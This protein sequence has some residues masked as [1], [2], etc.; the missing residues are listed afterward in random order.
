MNGALHSSGLKPPGQVIS[1]TEIIREKW[2]VPII[3]KG[4]GMGMMVEYDNG[5][6]ICPG[7]EQFIAYVQFHRD[8]C[9][10]QRDDSLNNH[11]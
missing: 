10:K 8:T 4:E 3:D 9:G 7:S 5:N 11:N 2:N 6:P 1:M